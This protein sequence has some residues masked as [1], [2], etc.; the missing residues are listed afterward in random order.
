L[1][2]SIFNMTVEHEGWGYV[3]A[4]GAEGIV[5]VLVPI[6]STPMSHSTNISLP[7]SKTPSELENRGGWIVAPYAEGRGEYSPPDEP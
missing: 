3:P 1:V 5:E 2:L 4:K 6:E 7:A